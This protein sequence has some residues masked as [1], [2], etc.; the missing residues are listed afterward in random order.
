[1]EELIQALKVNL[2]SHFAFYLKAQYYHWNVTGP[3]FSQ[4][5]NLLEGIYS[6]VYGTVDVIAEEIRGLDAYAPGGLTR[7]SQLTLIKDDETIPPALTMLNNLLSDI[8]IIQT[9]IKAVY[10]LAE[11]AGQHNLSNLMA[12]RQD[13][14]T[15]HAW[16]LRSTL[17]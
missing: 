10:D 14:F 7:Y 2:A 16:M 4:Y 12:E 17:K 8:G 3:D 5:H 1:M 13:A 9:N 11:Q 6:E 15:K